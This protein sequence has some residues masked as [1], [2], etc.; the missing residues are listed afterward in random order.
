MTFIPDEKITGRLLRTQYLTSGTSYSKL[1]ATKLLVL[2]LWGGGGAG[3][4]ATTVAVS[5]GAAGGGGGGSY[6]FK[7]F[8]VTSFAGPFTYAVGTGGTAVSGGT[9]N[10][11]NDSTFTVNSVTVTAKGGKGAIGNTTPGTAPLHYP[12][13]AGQLSTGGDVNGGGAPGLQG[14]TVSAT[15]GASGNGGSALFGRCGIG[16]TTAGAGNIGSGYGAGGSGGLVLNGSAQVAGGNGVN[17][18]IIV[19]EFS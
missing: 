19:R 3:G 15:V 10:D 12:G 8:D 18:L 7:S 14:I 11:G 13:G 9:G 2:E 16:R 17:G 5:S 4:G 6:A 1:S